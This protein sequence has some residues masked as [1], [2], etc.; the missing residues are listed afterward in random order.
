MPPRPVSSLA[1]EL[2]RLVAGRPAARDA[3]ARAIADED[4][5]TLRRLLGA[6]GLDAAAESVELLLDK[7]GPFLPSPAGWT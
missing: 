7:P 3:V 6:L 2:A 5:S 4:A 1:F